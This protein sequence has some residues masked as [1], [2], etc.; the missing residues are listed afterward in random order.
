MSSRGE[1]LTLSD[2]KRFNRLLLIA[3]F[4]AASHVPIA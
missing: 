3:A 2:E 4:V 1:M